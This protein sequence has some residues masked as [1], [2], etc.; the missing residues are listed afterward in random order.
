MKLHLTLACALTLSLAL[1]LTLAFALTCNLRLMLTLTFALA[2]TLAL[3][4]TLPLARKGISKCQQLKETTLPTSA[5]CELTLKNRD[6][7]ATDHSSLT[8]TCIRCTLRTL[9]ENHANRSV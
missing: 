6:R 3:T 1:T 9:I 7:H 4:L 8:P 2:I 5:K